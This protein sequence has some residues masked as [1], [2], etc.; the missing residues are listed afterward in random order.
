MRDALLNERGILAMK[1]RGLAAAERY[2]TLSIMLTPS[3]LLA[4][5]AESNPFFRRVVF[6]TPEKQWVLMSVVPG[7]EIGKETHKHVRQTFYF[8]SGHGLAM[9]GKDADP[10]IVSAGDMVTIA[11]GTTHNFITTGDRP[12]KLYTTYEPPNHID[13]RVHETKR[14]AD[15]DAMDEAFGERV[16]DPK[17]ARRRSR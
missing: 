5:W 17:K 6:T 4:E 1:S 14:A 2:V 11:P 9:I 3:P 12:L 10:M 13:G 15:R 16:D 7:E 8:V